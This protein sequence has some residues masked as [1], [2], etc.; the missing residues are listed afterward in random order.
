MQQF[1]PNG[2]WYIEVP[3]QQQ[4]HPET[5]Q[6]EFVLPPFLSFYFVAGQSHGELKTNQQT[7]NDEQRYSSYCRIIVSNCRRFNHI[8]S[9]MLIAFL[10]FR[11]SHLWFNYLW[12]IC[13]MISSYPSCWGKS[14]YTNLGK[15]HQNKWFAS[16]KSMKTVKDLELI[17]K[18]MFF[19]P[20]CGLKSGPRNPDLPLLRSR[21][22]ANDLPGGRVP[23]SLQSTMPW[24]TFWLRNLKKW[25]KDL[26]IYLEHPGIRK[27]EPLPGQ[28]HKNKVVAN[29]TNKSLRRKT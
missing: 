29:E 9:L 20:T 22:G 3:F 23:G 21:V 19:C 24:V 4:K 10:A 27:L 14:T 26:Y 12:Y 2:A 16:P 28:K 13:H 17:S 18:N 25:L 6:P 5:N 8:Y 7:G 11:A 1:V 15:K